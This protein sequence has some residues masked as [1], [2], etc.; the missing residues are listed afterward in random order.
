MQLFGN[1]I[2][3]AG[4]FM[5]YYCGAVHRWIPGSDASAREC[6]LVVG[7]F[8]KPIRRRPASSTAAVPLD[9]EDTVDFESEYSSSSG[10]PPGPNDP[11]AHCSEHGAVYDVGDL[12]VCFNIEVIGTPARRKRA[13]LEKAAQLRDCAR[14]RCKQGKPASLNV[15]AHPSLDDHGGH[16]TDPE[17]PSKTKEHVLEESRC[18]DQGLAQTS[19]ASDSVCIPGETG[20]RWVIV[21]VTVCLCACVCV[22]SAR[23]SRLHDALGSQ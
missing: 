23:R 4:C 18:S 7:K 2:E 15:P 10:L 12:C 8:M 21:G 6:F 13:R 9:P 22:C 17:Q 20:L 19:H 16:A 1:C 3:F 5:K 14:R 11:I